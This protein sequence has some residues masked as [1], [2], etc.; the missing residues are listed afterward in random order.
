MP[1]S[2]IQNSNAQYLFLKAAVKILE[3]SSS[4]VVFKVNGGRSVGDIGTH[5]EVVG[6]PLVVLGF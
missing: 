4:H 6:N 5:D 3:V 1:P 2:V